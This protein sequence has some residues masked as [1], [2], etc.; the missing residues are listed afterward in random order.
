MNRKHT[1]GKKKFDCGGQ[2]SAVIKSA[3]KPCW[4]LVVMKVYLDMST[5][6]CMRGKTK[7]S[8]NEIQLKC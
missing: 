6:T 3:R 8:S 2:D 5:N 7:R 4:G 1:G